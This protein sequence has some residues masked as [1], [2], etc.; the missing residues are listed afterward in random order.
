MKTDDQEGVYG[1]SLG[2]RTSTAEREI[3]FR[4]KGQRKGK[5]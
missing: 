4:E 3:C 2:I 1:R 5:I